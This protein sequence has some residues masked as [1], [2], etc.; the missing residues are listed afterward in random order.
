[1]NEEERIREKVA[2]WLKGFKEFLD[3]RDWDKVYGASEKLM[4]LSQ[5]KEIL[6]IKGI[7]TEKDI[8]E[9]E[10]RGIKKVVDWINKHPV[11]MQS[12]T[13]GIKTPIQ[14]EPEWDAF[15]KEVE[16]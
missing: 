13:L 5:S 11:Y 14:V 3:T 4:Y 6:S 12:N 9:A 16:K 1:M 15:Q 2:E 7:Y 10:Q 8:K